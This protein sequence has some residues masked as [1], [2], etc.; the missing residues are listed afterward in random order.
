VEEG[1]GRPTEG[2]VEEDLLEGAGDEIGAAD[3]L[4][5][6]HPVVIDD[7][8][9]LVGGQAVLSPDEKIAE[10]APRG[11]GLGALSAVEEGEGGGGIRDAK[12]PVD[13]GIRE[14]ERGAGFWGAAGSGVVFGGVGLV[15]RRESEGDFPAGA[16]AG[17]EESL[18]AELFEGLS[19]EGKA[20]A[21]AVGAEGTGVI[22]AFLPMDAQPEEVFDCGGL[23]FFLGAQGV[24]V[25]G[26]EDEGAPSGL[27][28][29]ESGPEGGGVSEVEKAGGGGGDSAAV[30]GTR[31]LH[32]K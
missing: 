17:V 7:G 22:G 29:L 6:F 3:D 21:L 14:G 19:V 25:V 27:G 5:D 20:E 24:E 16:G 2:A 10:I 18:S 31:I 23:E 30:G 4:G 9:Q 1:G 13:W 8:G 12:A 15:G 28:S 26:A 32:G 11:C